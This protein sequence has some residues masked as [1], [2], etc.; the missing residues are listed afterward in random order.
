MTKKDICGLDFGTSNTAISIPNGNAVELVP[1]EGLNTTIPSAMFF[2]FDGEE[3]TYGRQAITEYT[4]QFS[5]RLIRSLKSALGTDIATE[6]TRILNDD[7]S[8]ENL[9]SCYLDEIKRRVE[10]DTGRK[11]RRVVMGRPVNFNDE[12]KHKNAEAE[13][14]LQR[15]LEAIG[16][17]EVSFMYEPVA[18]WEYAK[19][20]SQQGKMFLVF[21]SG[22]GTTD[23]SIVHI[24]NND[25]EHFLASGGIKWAGTNID[26]ELGMLRVM[27]VF[28][29][30]EK[31]RDRQLPHWVY[32]RLASWG[33]IFELYKRDERLML[34]GILKPV[35]AIPSMRRLSKVINS[36]LGHRV[37]GDVEQAKILL[38]THRQVNLTLDYIE[39]DF[40]VGISRNDMQDSIGK[41][42]VKLEKNL[43][44]VLSSADVTPDKIDVVLLTGG[45]SKIKD[46][47]ELL[48]QKFYNARFETS[49]T[50]GAVA[51]G[52]GLEAKKK[53]S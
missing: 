45:T 52:L 29:Y 8:F 12:K 35:Q 25:K 18:A 17:K 14:M 5:G 41:G 2:P 19:H 46:L 27:P 1:I 24:D 26:Y 16:F 37:V 4:S 48:H 39:K 30:G 9:I 7:L 11:L 43:N 28:G 33:R 10:K 22:G 36:M 20:K 40:A 34:D 51:T 49:D 47:Q 42:V 3:V 6:K 23:I 38:A 15:A 21:D 53:F 31:I 13:E 44:E 50:F 32:Q